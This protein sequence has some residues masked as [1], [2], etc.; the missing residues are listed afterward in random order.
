M[1]LYVALNMCVHF[2]QVA[3]KYSNALL[4]NWNSKFL[5]KLFCKFYI[6]RTQILS[7]V[8]KVSPD[9]GSKDQFSSQELQD[10]NKSSVMTTYKKWTGTTSRYSVTV[11]KS[12]LWLWQTLIPLKQTMT[13]KG[14]F[15]VLFLWLEA[16]RNNKICLF[17]DFDEEIT[18]NQ[19]QCL[20]S[21][22]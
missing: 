13:P 16:K 2:T 9:N 19:T 17:Q 7:P 10:S 5:K 15:T 4:S 1:K 6:L 14:C 12:Y 18:E 11:I 8:S 3:D 21:I 20:L 22:H